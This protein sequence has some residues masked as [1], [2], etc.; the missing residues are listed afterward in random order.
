MCTRAVAG[1]ALLTACHLGPICGWSV[2]QQAGTASATAPRLGYYTRVRSQ[3]GAAGLHQ[4]RAQAP[5]GEVDPLGPYG[6]QTSIGGGV[7]SVPRPYERAP[8][9]SPPARPEAPPVV[10]R[11]YFPGFRAGQGPNRNTVPHCVPSR[12]SMLRR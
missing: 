3:A 8:R 10:S 5:R 6:E 2:A 4:S 9:V 11:E 1:L 7:N 12:Q